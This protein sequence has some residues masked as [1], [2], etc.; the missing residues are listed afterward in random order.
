MKK[1]EP[2]TP[3]HLVI[4]K[5]E[6]NEELLETIADIRSKG[7]SQTARIFINSLALAVL[8]APKISK[9]GLRAALT[10]EGMV[11][12]MTSVVSRKAFIDYTKKNREFVKQR[13]WHGNIFKDPERKIEP[14]PNSV[15]YI[16]RSGNL[17]ITN[18]RNLIEAY[19]KWWQLAF[20]L[21]AKE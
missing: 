16:D 18:R 7:A 12:T 13:V 2:T 1:L 17:V 5:H 3:Q 11:A 8:I 4:P 10:G 15:A 19:K 6:L 21:G 9:F 14:A 20:P